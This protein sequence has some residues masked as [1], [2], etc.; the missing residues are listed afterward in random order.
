LRQIV[1]GLF[2]AG[3]GGTVDYQSLPVDELRQLSA[4]GDRKAQGELVKRFRAAN[5]DLLIVAGRSLVQFDNPNGHIRMSIRISENA[6]IDDICQN[7][8]TVAEWRR[9]LTEWQGRWKGRMIWSSKAALYTYLVSQKT[10]MSH[11]ALADWVNRVLVNLLEDAVEGEGEGCLTWHE[12][13][14]ILEWLGMSDEEARRWCSAI[15]EEIRAGREPFPPDGGP[16]DKARLS[17]QLRY[18][19]RLAEGV[20][21]TG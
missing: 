17:V 10:H 8:H 12:S 14:A 18:W 2:V 21:K 16:I 1:A 13:L 5:S 20:G 6:S 15:S 7:W 3:R 9:R 4:E 19:R 11:A